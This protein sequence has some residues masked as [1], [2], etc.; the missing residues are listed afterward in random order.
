MA[1][2]DVGTKGWTPLLCAGHC[3]RLEV[4]QLLHRHGA[5]VNFVDA[6]GRTAFSLAF[7]AR[8]EPV[9]SYLRACGV[10]EHLGGG[11]TSLQTQTELYFK[12]GKTLP[13]T[14]PEKHASRR[15][16][17]TTPMR[18]RAERAGVEECSIAT[19]KRRLACE[20]GQRVAQGLP[21]KSLRS[22]TSTT[23]KWWIVRRLLHVLT[24]TNMTVACSG[25]RNHTA[26]ESS[27]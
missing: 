12:R 4:V 9:V 14:K 10:D 5:N 3:G 16:K 13:Q 23:T 11:R 18:E 21:R 15:S 26:K 1:P 7:R 8:H 27:R 17:R 2:N 22:S 6:S 19:G 20:N 25:M 24:V